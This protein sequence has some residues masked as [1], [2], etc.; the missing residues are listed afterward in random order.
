MAADWIDAF[1]RIDQRL[2]GWSGRYRAL[3]GR[4]R[5]TALTGNS[6][7]CILPLSDQLINGRS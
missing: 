3:V 6:E 5:R 1:V 4:H 2:V 7:A